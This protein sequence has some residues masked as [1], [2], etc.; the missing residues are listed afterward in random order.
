MRELPHKISKHWILF[1]TDYIRLTSSED[2]MAYDFAWGE[3]PMT[4]RKKHNL[5]TEVS[6]ELVTT[7]LASLWHGDLCETEKEE[8]YSVIK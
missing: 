8:F 5:N 1:E 3:V 6:S 4:Y 2:Q 7:S